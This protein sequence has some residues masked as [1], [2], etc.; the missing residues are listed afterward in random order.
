MGLIK[1]SVWSDVNQLNMPFI[2]TVLDFRRLEVLGRDIYMYLS[3]EVLDAPHAI[4]LLK[5]KRGKNIRLL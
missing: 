5:G 1:Q 2:D 3:I 4:E